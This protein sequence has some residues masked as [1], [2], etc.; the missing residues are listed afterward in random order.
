MD[1][2]YLLSYLL[3]AD[4]ELAE[5]CFVQGL[6]DARSGNRVF[7]DWAESWARRV[8]IMNAIRALRPTPNGPAKDSVVSAETM[9]DVPQVRAIVALPEFDRF[10]FV[11]TVL[12]GY[13]DRE[14]ALLFGC[15]R[16]AVASARVRVLQSLGDSERVKQ[17][18]WASD[19]GKA[20]R[21]DRS[22]SLCAAAT[23]ALPISA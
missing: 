22:L 10:V 23:A 21:P 8:V 19:C 11:A 3:T 7:K 6:Q 16:E 13:S 1:R 4:E 18:V 5:K 14:C 12:E 17:Q 9:V 15:T 2:L 20:L